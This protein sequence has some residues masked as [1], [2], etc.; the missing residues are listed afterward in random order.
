[1]PLSADYRD[2][3]LWHDRLGEPGPPQSL[4]ERADVAI[5][6]AGY[7]GLAAAQEL[8]SRGQRVVVFEAGDLGRGA[9]TRNA[10]MVIPELKQGL[11]SLRRRYG[12]LASP[13]VAA[14]HEAFELVEKLVHERRIDCDYR[15][16]GGLLLA[17]HPRQVAT[18][19]ELTDEL[20]EDLGET[21]RFVPRGEL[22]AEIGTARYEAAML[23]EATGGLHPASYHAGLLR[24]ARTA[25]AAVHEHTR[26]TS[27]EAHQ[28]EFSVMTTRGVLHAGDVLVAANAYVDRSFPPLQ[29]RVLPVGSFIIATEPLPPELA[30]QLI[31]NNRM[32]FDTRHFVRYWRR[33]PDDRLLFGGRAGLA[34]TSVVRARDTLYQ[35]MLGVYPQLHGA[36]ISHAWGGNVAIT[37]DRLPHCGRIDGIA[38]A[39][40]CNGTG[41]ALAT[42][43]G[44]QMAKSLTGE[45]LPVF[46]D[47][48][49]PRV[50]LHRW[51]RAWLPAAGWVLQG[52]DR[53]GR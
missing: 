36:R 49:F 41:L 13:L 47:L 9:S 27:I 48:P 29:R 17:H 3:P 46:S 20:V 8:A 45:R 7:C 50:P 24:L 5:V 21:A 25:G 10:G 38:Y 12:P 26:V 23:M 1:M 44:L 2:E 39:T 19:R 15:R 32:C 43:F 35:K 33:T 28:S 11:R 14:V 37:R 53:I 34:P 4:P 40:G 52:L 6:G 22:A 42:W 18:L 30:S 31:P 51:R 16:S